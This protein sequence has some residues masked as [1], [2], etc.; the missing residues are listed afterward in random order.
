ML[1]SS[2]KIN[3]SWVRVFIITLGTLLTL[4]TAMQNLF[5]H[6]CD[7]EAF[8]KNGDWVEKYTKSLIF[9][10]KFTLCG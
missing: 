2:K 6:D 3:H 8:K 1:H 7:G 5:Q 4:E 10:A 9:K